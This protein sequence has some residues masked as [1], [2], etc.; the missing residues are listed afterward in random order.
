MKPITQTK[1][2]LVAILT[3]FA[4]TAEA[5]LDDGKVSRTEAL[6]ICFKHAGAA[7]TAISG[8]TDVPEEL[9][10]LSEAELEEL[11]QAALDSQ[12][13]PD[14]EEN[15]QIV[16]SVQDTIRNSMQSIRLIVAKSQP[17]PPAPVAEPSEPFPLQPVDY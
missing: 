4:A 12:A 6:A 15:R 3:G 16:R 7:W 8:I 17:R 9:A 2:L 5:K 14:T 10:D 1:E 13:W 11:T